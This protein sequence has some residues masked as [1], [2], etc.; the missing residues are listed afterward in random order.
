MVNNHGSAFLGK[1][2]LGENYL[3]PRENVENALTRRRVDL[4]NQTTPQFLT[5]TSLLT[6]S[7]L[8]NCKYCKEQSTSYREQIATVQ[9]PLQWLDS[10]NWCQLGTTDTLV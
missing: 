5:R 8:G 4:S 2:L 6:V 7:G 9:L 3:L 1:N 10:S